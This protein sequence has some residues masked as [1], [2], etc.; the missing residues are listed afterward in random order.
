MIQLV[1]SYLTNRTLKVR[2]ENTYSTER[3]ITARVPWAQSWVPHNSIS[4]WRTSHRHSSSMTRKLTEDH[5]NIKTSVAK[6]RKMPPEHAQI[7]SKNIISWSKSAKYLGVILE[8]KLTFKEH[9]ENSTQKA[10]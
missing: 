10:K 4:S 3:P 8:N 1:R 7:R 9:L 6:T 2:I 5:M